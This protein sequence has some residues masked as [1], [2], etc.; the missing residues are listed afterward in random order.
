MMYKLGLCAESKWRW[1]RGF[2]E[3]DRVIRGVKFRNGINYN[4][5]DQ[6]AA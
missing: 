5:N 3:L 4:E 2:K 6:V 1:L